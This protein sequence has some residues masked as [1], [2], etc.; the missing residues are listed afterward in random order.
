MGFFLSFPDN[1][2]GQLMLIITGVTNP[3]FAKPLCHRNHLDIFLNYRLD[4]VSVKPKILLL[5]SFQ[6]MAILLLT[7]KSTS[8]LPGNVAFPLTQ[9]AAHKPQPIIR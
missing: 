6:K 2:N 1:F 9:T 8:K 3:L 4:V 7:H 5:L